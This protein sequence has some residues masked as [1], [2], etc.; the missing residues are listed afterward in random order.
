MAKP[1]PVLINAMRRAAEKLEK[2]ANYQWGHMGACNC[3]HLAQELTRL[4]QGEIHDYAMRKQ[5]D[6]TDQVM[7]FCPSSGLPMDLLISE[8]LDYGLDLADLKH[9][10]KL[11]DPSILKRLRPE[12][13]YLEHNKRE[14][15]I[16]YLHTWANLLE[17]DLLE[18]VKIPEIR[19]PKTMGV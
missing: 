4:K 18:Q 12:H 6:W 5:G 17:E 19:T 2:G 10:E 14:H 8:L 11:S 15:V 16:L 3:G 7:D 9:L 13:R 1:E